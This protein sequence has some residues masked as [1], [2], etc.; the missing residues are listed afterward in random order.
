MTMF[1]LTL[2]GSNAAS[3][4]SAH[5]SV[6]VAT[7]MPED[8]LTQHLVDAGLFVPEGL[9]TSIAAV[10]G[11]GNAVQPDFV[12]PGQLPALK[13]RCKVLTGQFPTV[14]DAY[15]LL[16][17]SDEFLEDWQQDSPRDPQYI[18]RQAEY[19]AIRPMFELAPDLL[20]LAQAVYPNLE[21]LSAHTFRLTYASSET[22]QWIGLA[23]RTVS[24]WAAQTN[25]ASPQS[26]HESLF[27][28]LEHLRRLRDVH[29]S[30]VLNLKP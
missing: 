7:S 14:L 12:L 11:F 16:A 18:E 2:R 21:M 1:E 13:V 5:R 19:D 10:G 25:D 9:V 3:K 6:L 4:E 27:E 28:C 30:R 8:L 29:A 17:L 22:Q 23:N 15:R 26:E 20:A 24:K